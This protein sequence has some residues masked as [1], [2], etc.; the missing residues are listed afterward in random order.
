MCFN[1]TLDL[2]IISNNMHPKFIQISTRCVFKE[3]Y[4]IFGLHVI[5]E[6]LSSRSHHSMFNHYAFTLCCIS[7]EAVD[8]RERRQFLDAIGAE[9]HSDLVK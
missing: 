4:I 6:C 7:D 3:A 5:P 9:G 1:F 2:K 8:S